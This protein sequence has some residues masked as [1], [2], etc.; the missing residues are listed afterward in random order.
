MT[1]LLVR[2]KVEDYARWKPVFD[3]TVPWLKEDG[4]QEAVVMRGEGDPN[5]IYVAIRWETPEAGRKFLTSGRLQDAMRRAGVL[6]EPEAHYLETLDHVYIGE[7]EAGQRA[8]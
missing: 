8:G 6:G 7:A 1:W 4:A 2:H 5:L 3:E